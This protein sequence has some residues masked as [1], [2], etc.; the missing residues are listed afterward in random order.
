M[1]TSA[2]YGARFRCEQVK[3]ERE[4]ELAL[5]RPVWGLG[6]GQKSSDSSDEKW[7]V[8]KFLCTLET[9]HA[10]DVAAVIIPATHGSE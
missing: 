2:M 5:V 9:P 7:P 8:E 10:T 1:T 3:E 6:N 4:P